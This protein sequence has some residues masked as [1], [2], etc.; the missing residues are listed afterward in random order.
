MYGHPEDYAP[1]ATESQAHAEWHLNAGVKIGPYGGS[2]PWDA[3][4][5]A[6][7]EDYELELAAQEARA[8]WLPIAPALREGEEWVTYYAEF[9]TFGPEPDYWGSDEPPF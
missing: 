6:F 8:K 9:Q 4:G 3:C 2:C 7:A 1:V 5:H